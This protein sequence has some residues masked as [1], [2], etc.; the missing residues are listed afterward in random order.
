M[1]GLAGIIFGQ[2]CRTRSELDYFGRV[3][4]Y[5]LLLSEER[6]PHA[7]GAAWLKSDGKYR[8]L[9]RQQLARDFCRDSDF[10][11]L[12]A[13]V[14]SSVTWLAG[15][16]R[17]QTCGDAFN[18]LNNHPILAGAVIGTHNGTVFNADELFRSLKLPRNAEVDSEV[19]FRMTDSILR[20]GHIDVAEL[21][22][23]LA[24]CKGGMSVVMASK[25]SPEEVVVVK[26]GKPLELRYSREYEAVVYASDARYLDM[27]LAGHK[28]W[29]LVDLNLMTIAVFRCNGLE[30][31][32]CESFGLDIPIEADDS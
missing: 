7:T 28:S 5:L 3:F 12:L 23:R 27:S 1:C 13:N 32:T 4:T 18:N 31:S 24:L 22:K 11:D 29:K 10:G 8:I 20:D 19:I 2:K 9:K 25:R 17:W 21:G 14:D 30:A 26:G 6:G 16:T 15:H